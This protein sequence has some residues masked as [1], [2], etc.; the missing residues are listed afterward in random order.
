MGRPRESPKLCAKSGSS[1]SVTRPSHRWGK[2]SVDLF[3]TLVKL[4]PPN[5]ILISVPDRGRGEAAHVVQQNPA[6]DMRAGKLPHGA[7]RAGV[8]RNRAGVDG[9][10]AGGGVRPAAH[11]AVPPGD[12]LG[13][14]PGAAGRLQ[15]DSQRG[16]PPQAGQPQNCPEAGH[17]QV[18]HQAGGERERERRRGE[19]LR[20]AATFQLRGSAG[21]FIFKH[22]Q[23]SVAFSVHCGRATVLRQVSTVN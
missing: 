5:P 17:A 23:A 12:Q 6:A 19:R 15:G 20:S 10:E 4:S 21:D 14:A 8:P 2:P 3:V 1:P 18:V 7:G 13:A 9:E 22:M 11:E 16:L